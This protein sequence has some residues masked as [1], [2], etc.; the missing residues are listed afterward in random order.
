MIKGKLKD[1]VINYYIE[2]I[3]NLINSMDSLYFDELCKT[4]H[5]FIEMCNVFIDYLKIELHKVSDEHG[6]IKYVTIVDGV[7]EEVSDKYD[8]TLLN[9]KKCCENQI[10]KIIK[11]KNIY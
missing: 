11:K 3:N 2:N 7:S 6:N 8:E 5:I 10:K 4:S 9:I 1:D